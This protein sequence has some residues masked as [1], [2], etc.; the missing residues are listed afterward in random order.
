MYTE[1]QYYAVNWCACVNQG[2]YLH[3]GDTNYLFFKDAG[4]LHSA[5][6]CHRDEETEGAKDGHIGQGE[7]G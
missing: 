1:R 3:Q 6:R 2:C 7:H 5:L 4:K